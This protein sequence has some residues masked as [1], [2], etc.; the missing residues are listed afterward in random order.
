MSATNFFKTYTQ[1]RDEIH[2][3]DVETLVYQDGVNAASLACS[4]IEIT[5]R[6][7]LANRGSPLSELNRDALDLHESFRL[8]VGVLKWHNF[9]QR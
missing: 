6:F 7:I 9:D 4:E 1:E 3:Q 5:S 2:T 8:T